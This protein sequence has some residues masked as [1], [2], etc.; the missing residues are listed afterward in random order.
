MQERI[1]R[2]WHLVITNGH[3]VLRSPLV[4]CVTTRKPAFPYISFRP[5]RRTQ[6]CL[7]SD[8]IYAD[9]FCS[10]LILYKRNITDQ[11]AWTFTW[12]QA[13]EPTNSK[14]IFKA[15]KYI[16]FNQHLTKILPTDQAWT[17]LAYKLTPIFLFKIFLSAWKCLLEWVGLLHPNCHFLLLRIFLVH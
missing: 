3:S 1:N 7:Y 6:K 15:L 2:P 12:A 5:G 4:K 13:G 10:F 17:Y 8:F 11:S 14:Y 9:L 16:F